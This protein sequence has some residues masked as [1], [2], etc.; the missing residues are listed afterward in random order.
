MY[1]VPQSLK[2]YLENI[3]TEINRIRVFSDEINCLCFWILICN[4]NLFNLLVLLL[5]SL[6]PSTV[7]LIAFWYNAICGGWVK[8]AMVNVK[9]L[10]KI[11]IYSKGYQIMKDQ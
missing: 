1:F 4:V 5:G 9:L 6:G 11:R 3:F 10:P 8:I 7:T 2:F